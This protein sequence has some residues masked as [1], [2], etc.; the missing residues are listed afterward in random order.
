MLIH[1][2]AV[3]DLNPSTGRWL[4]SGQSAIVN[5]S[6]PSNFWLSRPWSKDVRFGHWSMC[7][8][9][10]DDA[11]R[12]LGVCMS[13]R[14]VNPVSE[15]LSFTNV[16]GRDGNSIRSGQSN[17]TSSVSDGSNWPCC[18]ETHLLRLGIS[19][20]MSSLSDGK[21][22]ASLVP[23]NS[24]LIWIMAWKPPM[25]KNRVE[26][27]LQALVDSNSSYSQTGGYFASE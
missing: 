14:T 5:S 20:N 15:I 1:L 12:E 9:A 17:T 7:R 21:F 11:N 19:S 4:S 2:R 24:W 26:A 18:T 27:A 10:N 13:G 16:D 23:E 3:R 22:L 8:H 6:R 25:S